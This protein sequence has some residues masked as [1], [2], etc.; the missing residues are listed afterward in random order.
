MNKR[1]FISDAVMTG[2]VCCTIGAVVFYEINQ[3]IAKGYGFFHEY[4]G[5]II[6][7][8]FMLA[9]GLFTRNLSKYNRYKHDKERLASSTTTDY[10]KERQDK[11]WIR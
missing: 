1:S 8:L 9:A 10:V 5:S 7:F 4:G 6:V 2:V 3:G 11:T